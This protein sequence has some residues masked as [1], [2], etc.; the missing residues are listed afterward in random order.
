VGWWP[1]GQSPPNSRTMS[2][3]SPSTASAQHR[4]QP[5]RTRPAR[6]FPRI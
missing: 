4:E 6:H 3:S 2:G 1:W 5:D